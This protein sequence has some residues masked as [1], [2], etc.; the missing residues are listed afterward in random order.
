MVQASGYENRDLFA[1]A[2]QAGRER[3]LQVQAWLFTLQFWLFL[4]PAP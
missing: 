3:G 2:I 4:W 1:E